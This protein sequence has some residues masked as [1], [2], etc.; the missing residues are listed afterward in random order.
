[1]TP[2]ALLARFR[3]EMRDEVAPYLWSDS[4]IYAFMDQAQKDFCRYTGGIADI[5]SVSL[6]ASTS[7]YSVNPNI[8]KI[9]YASRTSDDVEVALINIGDIASGAYKLNTDEGTV[10]A[11]LTDVGTDEIRCIPVP[12]ASD[13]LSMI[14]KRMP[15]TDI[16]AGGDTIEIP[17]HHQPHLVSGMAYYAHRKQDAETFDRERAERYMQTF[18]Q[19][20][21]RAKAE[22][23]RREHKPRAVAYGGL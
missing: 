7:T 4:E 20:C 2:A 16:D 22:R 12:S 8:L 19:Y 21:D 9:E 3:T 1:M 18:L 10:E 11:V 5:L 13:T 6:V 23:E 17:E 14:V 15:L